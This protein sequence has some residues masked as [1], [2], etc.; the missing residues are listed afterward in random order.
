MFIPSKENYTEMTSTE[1]EKYTIAELTKQFSA[2]GIQN[3]SFQ[4]NV[5]IDAYDG[6]YQIDGKLEYSLMG[7]SYVTLVECKKYKGPIKREHIQALHDKIRSTGAHKG[8]FVTTSYYQ[9]GALKYA[10]KHGI[11]LISII[12]GS[13]RYA[14]RS[15]D[16]LDKPTIPPWVDVKPFNMVMQIQKNDASIS[17]SYI[18]DTDALFEFIVNDNVG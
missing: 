18:D 5:K 2:N 8:I 14:T 11:A 6:T 10:K 13:M 9:S 1:F 3:F 15:R 17:V 4:H 16:C 12:E 7:I